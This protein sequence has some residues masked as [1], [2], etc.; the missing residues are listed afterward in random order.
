MSLFTQFL[1]KVN[2]QVSWKHTNFFFLT[3]WDQKLT[4]PDSQHNT[5]AVLYITKACCSAKDQKVAGLGDSLEANCVALQALKVAQEADWSERWGLRHLAACASPVSTC[6]RSPCCS[7]AGWEQHRPLPPITPVAS[8]RRREAVCSQSN[9]VSA[10]SGLDDTSPGRR[11]KLDVTRRR[12]NPAP[13]GISPV[14]GGLASTSSASTR[15][16]PS[17]QSSGAPFHTSPWPTCTDEFTIALARFSL[18]QW[19]AFDLAP[20]PMTST[21]HLPPLCRRR[22]INPGWGGK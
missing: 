8:E 12:L 10:G 5:W 22:A 16:V 9:S 3:P 6:S 2:S 14:T 19:N 17:P 20:T 15:S 11:W 21:L 7:Q 18:R 13:R 4:V 1:L